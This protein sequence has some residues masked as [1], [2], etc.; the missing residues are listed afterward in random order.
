MTT[1]QPRI[2]MQSAIPPQRQI[3]WSGGVLRM[4]ALAAIVF[5]VLAAGGTKPA[6]AAS[7][8]E[9]TG[10]RF[11][12]SGTRTRVVLDLD[13]SVTY[14]VQVQT[15]PN[16]LTIDLDAVQW[17]R[18]AQCRR[19]PAWA[20]AGAPFQP[21]DAGQIALRGRDGATGPHRWRHPAAAI[22]G[23]P[24]LPA[25][26]RRRSRPQRGIG[27]R[28]AAGGRPCAHAGDPQPPGAVRTCARTGPGAQAAA[29]LPVVVLDPGHGGIDPGATAID[30]DY[31]K[32]LV[33]EMAK[34]LRALIERSGRYRVVLTRDG[35]EFIQLRDRIA[36][37]RRAGRQHR[38]S[39]SM[40]TACGW[41]SSAAPRSTRSR[42]RRRTP[43]RRGSPARR[44]RPTSWPAPT[45]RSTTRWWRRS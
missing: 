9:V 37:A 40:P 14:D 20:G 23:Q 13:R 15:A 38:S 30:G 16:Q 28:G 34:E 21:A 3:W 29:R 5:C 41:P 26:G 36:K 33:L 44:T 1:G 42:R 12:A 17:Q 45:C 35:D 22:T 4:L 6:G 7:A 25:G 8:G 24:H 43:R 18:A 2:S 27:S 32:D 10:L 11:G 39:R 19:T 31:E